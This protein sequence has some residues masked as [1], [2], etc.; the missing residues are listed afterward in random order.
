MQLV[1]ERLKITAFGART[2]LHVILRRMS[3]QNE[4]NQRG[5]DTFEPREI[6][7]LSC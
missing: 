4:A 3:A 6:S 7:K 2:H 5:V 1:E